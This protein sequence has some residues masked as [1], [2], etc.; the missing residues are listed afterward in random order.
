MAVAKDQVASKLPYVWDFSV[1]AIDQWHYD[2]KVM[3]KHPDT[4]IINVGEFAEQTY[5]LA[6]SVSWSHADAC[7]E[8][9]VS[10]R[11]PS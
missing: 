4:L 6:P 7:T 11:F 10:R 1:D 3:Q 8:L 9:S 5:L 2:T